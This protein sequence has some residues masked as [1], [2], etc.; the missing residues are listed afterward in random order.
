MLVAET[1]RRR[2][3]EVIQAM[4]FSGRPNAP[5]SRSIHLPFYR[6]RSFGVASLTIRIL[7]GVTGCI[8]HLENSIVGISILHCWSQRT[9]T[10]TDGFRDRRR[11]GT[12]KFGIGFGRRR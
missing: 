10:N 3:D 1:L 12:L 6:W 11:T 5:G 9:T 2:R 7:K 4:L 8:E